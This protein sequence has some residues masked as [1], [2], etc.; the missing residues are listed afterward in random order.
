MIHSFVKVETRRERKGRGGEYE[1]YENGKK[2]WKNVVRDICGREE[3]RG[4]RRKECE[5][6]KDWSKREVEREWMRIG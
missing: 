3:G 4:G 2:D 6:M 5:E 1:E